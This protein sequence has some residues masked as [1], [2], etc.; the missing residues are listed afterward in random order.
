LTLTADTYTTFR[1]N[2]KNSYVLAGAEKNVKV[3][4]VAG[5]NTF[6]FTNASGNFE[7]SV[8]EVDITETIYVSEAWNA[9]T[10]ESGMVFGVNA[11]STF[12]E[13]GSEITSGIRTIQYTA[14]ADGTLSLT[15]TADTYTTF[16][17]NGKNSYVLANGE[18]TVEFDVVNGETYTI[19]FTNAS[20]DYDLS[21]SFEA[22]VLPTGGVST[23]DDTYDAGVNKLDFASADASFSNWVGAEDIVD[24]FEVTNFD[25]K[26]TTF[27]LSVEDGDTRATAVIYA[28]AAGSS[29][30]RQMRSWSTVS[31]TSSTLALAE[32]TKYF[33]KVTSTGSSSYTM[34]LA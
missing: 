30:L 24:W 4:L 32:G 22:A 3:D 19:E 26:R 5:D 23:A 20:G 34:Q 2:G 28:Q 16:R 13:I 8:Q 10:V 31:S 17:Y 33:V 11:F 9:D 7:L 21:A 15:L 29:S 27:T 6:E 25:A 14:T 12:G 18:K 1:Y